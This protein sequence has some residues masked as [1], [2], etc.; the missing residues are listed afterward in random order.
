MNDSFVFA[1]SLVLARIQVADRDGLLSR[2]VATLVEAVPALDP[3]TAL[4]RLQQREAQAPTVVAPGVAFPHALVPGLQRECLCVATLREPLAYGGP[5]D[6]A[7][8]LVFLLLGPGDRPGTHLKTLSA[9]ARRCSEQEFLATAWEAPTDAALW[10][11]V[12]PLIDA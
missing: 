3:D 2:M 8:R 10:E 12:G 1:P 11:V 6:P 7:V 9:L 5:D 4:F